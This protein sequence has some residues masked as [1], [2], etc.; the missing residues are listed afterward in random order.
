MPSRLSPHWLKVKEVGEKA[1]SWT[2]LLG[3]GFTKQEAK[4]ITSPKIFRSLLLVKFFSSLEVGIGNWAQQCSL[5]ESK[6]GIQFWREWSWANVIPTWIV[7]KSRLCSPDY[8]RSREASNGLAKALKVEQYLACRN[9]VSPE[10]SL[11]M[12]HVESR[13][14]LPNHI[15]KSNQIKPSISYI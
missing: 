8:Q 5:H 6:I 13:R 12:L 15:H 7:M 3:T 4:V 9:Q 14:W 1:E 10:A 2:L 11:L